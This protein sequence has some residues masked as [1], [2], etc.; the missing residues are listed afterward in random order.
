M[1]ILDDLKQQA[2]QARKEKEDKEIRQAELERIYQTGIRPAMLNI[3]KYLTDLIEQLAAVQWSVTLGFDFP[4]IGRVGNLAQQDYKLTI[5]SQR[6]PK[7][8]LLRFDCI[9]PEDKRYIV[10]SRAALD[11][12]SQ[13][14]LAQKVPFT[15][16][17]IR[18]SLHE[19]TG[20]VIQAKLR[21]RTSLSF[22]ADI[23][24]GLIVVT[25][26][27]FQG[28]VEKGFSAHYTAITDEWLD[29]LGHYILRK[30]TA[31][32]RLDISEEERNRIRW[33]LEEERRQYEAELANSPKE[34]VSENGLLPRLRKILNMQ[35]R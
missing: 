16:W 32:G 24:N 22:D 30:N 23:E 1:G 2:N 31:F 12:A 3:H 28:I 15:D 4:G 6:N 34:E 14:L 7:F 18:D 21:V 13:F 5:D 17:A 33:L 35:G 8:V 26:L 25:A 10:P 20:F 9:A 27:N 29:Q 19:I 11:E